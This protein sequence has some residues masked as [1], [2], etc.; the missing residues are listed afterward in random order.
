MGSTKYEVQ[1]PT[2][3]AQPTATASLAEYIQNLPQ[4]YDVESQYQ[5]KYAQLEKSINEQLYPYTSGLQEQLAQQASEGVKSGVPDWAQKQYISDVNARLGTNV[6]SRIGADY[7]SRGLLSQTM[8]WQ[9]Y[10]RNL[11]LSLANRQQLASP[12]SLTSTFNPGSIMGMNT[13]T[14]SPYASAYTNMY[15]TNAQMSQQ[16]SPWANIAGTVLGQGVGTF[17]GLGSY[18]LAKKAGIF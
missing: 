10:Y 5:P 1:T 16:S 7:A 4:L 6:N 12:Q 18:G 14:Y 11:G 13:S 2:P 15:N 9:N 17:T 3:P 8:D